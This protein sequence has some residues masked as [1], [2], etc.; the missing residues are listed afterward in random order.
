LAASPSKSETVTSAASAGA[1]ASVYVPGLRR[2]GL[3]DADQLRGGVDLGGD[4]RSALLHR[5]TLEGLGIRAGGHHDPIRRLATSGAAV[6]ALLGARLD[7]EL[8][9]HLGGDLGQSDGT[10]RFGLTV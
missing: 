6:T 9:L 7:G 3:L 8:H 10:E 5:Q 2:A 1:A 4:I